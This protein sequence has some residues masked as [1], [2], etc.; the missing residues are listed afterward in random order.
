M[1]KRNRVYG[2]MV[3]I[4]IGFAFWGGIQKPSGVMTGKPSELSEESEQQ[5]PG[6]ITTAAEKTTGAEKNG[7]RLHALSAVLM[8]GD[9]GRIR[10]PVQQRS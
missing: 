7:L 6:I 9:S 3:G 8:D 10:W 4:T 5:N 2:L 1:G